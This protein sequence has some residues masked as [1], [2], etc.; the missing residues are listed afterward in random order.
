MGFSGITVVQGSPLGK[1]FVHPLQLTSRK[2]ICL[3]DRLKGL[4]VLDVDYG[5]IIVPPQ[6]CLF[7]LSRI[8]SVV[9]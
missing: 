6:R 2:V 8:I 9:E 5:E 7:Y 1:I 4:L 3:C